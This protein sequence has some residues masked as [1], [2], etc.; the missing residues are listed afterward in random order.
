MLIINGFVHIFLTYGNFQCFD[1]IVFCFYTPKQLCWQSQVRKICLYFLQNWPGAFII[2]FLI[3][4][5][6]RKDL[7]ECSSKCMG[8]GKISHRTI[9]LN[10]LV[11][12]DSSVLTLI[13]FLLWYTFVHSTKMLL[14]C[15]SFSLCFCFSYQFLDRNSK[16]LFHILIL[17]Y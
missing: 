16:T 13:I 7:M 3:N 14:W 9:V 8:S 12:A 11:D 6:M 10:S 1:G 2:H 4:G 17:L 15:L 5:F